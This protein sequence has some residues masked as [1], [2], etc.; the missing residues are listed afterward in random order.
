MQG[1]GLLAGNTLR[2]FD[3]GCGDAVAS[4]AQDGKT[5]RKPL[6]RPDLL[7]RSRLP[8]PGT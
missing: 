2:D 5:R 8:Q 4:P 7:R 3:R 6:P 1:A